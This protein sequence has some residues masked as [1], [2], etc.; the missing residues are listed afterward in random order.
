MSGISEG[1]SVCVVVGVVLCVVISVFACV[2]VS[3][4]ICMKLYVGLFVGFMLRISGTLCVIEWGAG[5]YV[6]CLVV[7]VVGWFCACMCTYVF[8]CV[9]VCVVACAA[10]VLAALGVAGAF[11][12][13]YF[14][15]AI[16]LF[17]ILVLQI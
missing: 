11:L 14:G 17:L 15:T 4:D 2:V 5:C 13:G 6:V 3:L 8:S 7:Q 1:N 16:L 12:F 9:V 10:S